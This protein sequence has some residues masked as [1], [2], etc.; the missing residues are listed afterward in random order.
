MKPWYIKILKKISYALLLPISKWYASNERKTTIDNIAITIKAGVFHPGL[1]FST[2]FLLCWIKRQR[3]LYLS[4][5]ELGA[6]TGL[7]SVFSAK[8]GAKVTATDISENAIQNL[9]INSE[10]NNAPIH[11]IHSDLFMDIPWQHF[12]LLLIN[13]PYYPKNPTNEDECAWYCG[14]DFDYFQ[15]LFF[16]MKLFMKESSKA[17][18]VLSDDCKID[19]IQSLALQNNYKWQ[20]IVSKRSLLEE[21]YL[22][23]ITI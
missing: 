23:Q 16:Q 11:I 22:F 20:L 5:I 13:P 3:L 9:K 18:M 8:N 19:V 21:N 2:K 1:F 14:E 12:D 7:L 10:N 4:I 6:G 17:I 15:K